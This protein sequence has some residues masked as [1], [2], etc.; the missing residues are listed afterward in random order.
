MNTMRLNYIKPE[1]EIFSI[2]M[3]L[4]ALLTFSQV[5]N[6]GDKNTDQ[7]PIYEGD[8]EGGIG[9]NQWLFD[10]EDEGWG[11]QGYNYW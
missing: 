7:R 4:P 1:I 11:Y 9:A 5:D 8:P 2:N 10:D 6:D 3:G